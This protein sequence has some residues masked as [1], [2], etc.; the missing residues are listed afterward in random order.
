MTLCV[1]LPGAMTFGVLIY[2]CLG[3]CL[4]AVFL[5]APGEEM[6]PALPAL[7]LGLIMK[8]LH[9]RKMKEEDQPLV[10]VLLGT[11]MCF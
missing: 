2:L 10:G 11:A 9:R 4:K 7:P 8:C 5:K 1:E 3:T 6:L